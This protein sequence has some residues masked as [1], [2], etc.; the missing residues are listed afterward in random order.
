MKTIDVA[1]LGGGLAGLNAARLLHRV[2]IQFHLFEARDRLGG[3]ILTVDETGESDSNGFDL[4]PSWFWPG[5]QPQLAA[6][7]SEL[8]VPIFAQHTAGDMLFERSLREPPQ[9]VEGAGQDQGSMRLVGG[10]GALVRALAKDLPAACI[11]LNA[12]VTDLQLVAEGI[13]LTIVGGG[14]PGETLVAR[15]VISTL[16]PR[17]MAE[18]IRLDPVMDTA[19]VSHWRKTPTWMAPH[20]KFFAIYDCPFWREDGLSGMAQSLAGP[21]AEVHDATTAFGD[22]ALF[23]FVGLPVKTRAELS[24]DGMIRAATGQLARLFGNQ[25]ATPRATLLQDW[26]MEPFTAT[27]A[28][29]AASGHPTAIRAP[30]LNRAWMDRLTLAGSETSTTEPGYL[31]G[32]VEASHR[33][34]LAYINRRAV[35]TARTTGAG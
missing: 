20:A 27:E 2:G 18:A 9:R 26:A 1:I 7:V 17:L 23:G 33:V 21:L 29:S 24:R 14:Q 12:P 6:L 11:R 31:A 25:A 35:S 22:A 5:M 13:L 8:G 15:H 16:P 28:D 32:A 4:G 30:V 3:R 19:T 10:M 34:T